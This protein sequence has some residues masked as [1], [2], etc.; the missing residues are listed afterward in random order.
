[1]PRLIFVVKTG[2]GAEGI[3]TV[4]AQASRKPVRQL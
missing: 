4:A 3:G 1:M 2:G